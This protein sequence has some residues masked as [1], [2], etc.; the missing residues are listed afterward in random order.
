MFK[1]LNCF[2]KGNFE[3]E[4]EGRQDPLNP[5]VFQMYL[6][7]RDPK[8]KEKRVSSCFSSSRVSAPTA[9]PAASAIFLE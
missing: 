3:N 4:D 5:S 6:S 8:R 1:S 7:S 2:V 9:S